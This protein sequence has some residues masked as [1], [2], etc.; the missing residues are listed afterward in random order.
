MDRLDEL[1]VFLAV[2]ETGS[3]AGAA[4]RL[5]RSPAAVTRTLASLETRVGARLIERTTRSLAVTEV[6]RHVA[7]D[8]RRTL[9][10]YQVTVEREETGR[11]G[12]HLRL[13]APVEF[14]RRHVA[15]VVSRFLNAHPA[16]TAELVLNDRNLDLVDE[17]LDL[18]VRIGRLADS[19]LVVRKLGE[20]RRMI[21]A[22][23]AYL[24]HCGAPR[25]PA[26]LAGHEI[27]FGS[28]VAGPT[29]WRFEG[30]R[31]PVSV[32]LRPRL[33][34]N[35]MEPVIGAVV[36]GKG[37]TRA[38]SYQVAGEIADG[39]LVRLLAEFESAPLPVQLV[40]PSARLTPPR[41]RAFL[42]FAVAELTALDV[43]RPD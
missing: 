32:R 16:V 6:G 18:A 24:D 27:I 33:M 12:G 40:T 39:R 35:A 9:A 21:V 43:L 37:I 5:R 38:L 8:A 30:P 1:A 15:P 19:G 25:A 23:P 17:G 34:I 22:A 13:S 36:A 29:E 2:L 41:V 14:G 11:L 4:R 31:G 26:D 3:L 28:T 7:E 10:A 42:D 20:V